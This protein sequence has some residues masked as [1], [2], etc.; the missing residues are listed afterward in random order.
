[1]TEILYDLSPEALVRANEANMYSFT[2]FS[3]NWP[4]AEVY[5]GNDLCWV[6]TDI[7][8]PSCNVA[9]KANLQPENVDQAIESFVEKGK[10][11]NVLLNWYI[12]HDTR[13]AD[14]GSHL[15]RHGFL[16]DGDSR[17]MAIDLLAMNEA[18]PQTDDLVI[19][20]VKNLRDLKVW[21]KTTITGFGIP[22]QVEPALYKLFSTSR[23]LKLPQRFYL[24]W[25]KDQPVATS[26][27]YFAEGV[28]GIYF[29]S[30]LPDARNHGIGFAITQKPLQV[31]TEMGYRVATLQASRMGYP[32]YI[33]M[34]FKEYSKIGSYIWMP[35]PMR[36]QG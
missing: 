32:V 34:G 36:P 3:H 22:A 15:K 18:E 26:M 29:V 25:W 35:E 10:A 11:R 24:A 16:H 5:A 9:F 4:K 6:I 14:L 31:A 23:K 27:V 28:A 7:P 20:E 21:V 19:T 33:R 2:P 12:G 30:T 17:G 8:F 1:M 13:P